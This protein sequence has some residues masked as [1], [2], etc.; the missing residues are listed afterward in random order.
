MFSSPILE[1]YWVALICRKSASQLLH[2]YLKIRPNMLIWR[3]IIIKAF[4]HC[5]NFESKESPYCTLKVRDFFLSLR[6]KWC[7]SITRFTA[8][9]HSQCF[10]VFT[11]AFPLPLKHLFCKSCI[12]TTHYQARFWGLK[13]IRDISKLYALVPALQNQK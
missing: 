5:P 12:I 4:Y 9:M 13:K 3:S 11:T 7:D 10:V 1:H 6:N 2:S 8:C